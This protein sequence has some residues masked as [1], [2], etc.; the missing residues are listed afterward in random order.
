MVKTTSEAA[1]GTV[2]YMSPEQVL[3]RDL[4]HRSDLFSL[5]VVL[6]EMAT[7]R[8]PFAGANSAETVERI[9]TAQAPDISRFRREVPRVLER[10]VSKCLEKDR[11]RR[12]VSTRELLA[13]LKIARR[14]LDEG[15]RN[16]QSPA[17]YPAIDRSQRARHTPSAVA[18][19]VVFAAASA[20]FVSRFRQLAEPPSREYT[21]LTNFADSARWPTL[22]SDGRMLA[23]IRGEVSRPG[24]VYVKLL[25]DGEPTRLTDDGL[26]KQ[27]PKFSPDGARIAYGALNP[28][29]GWDT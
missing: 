25:P 14:D 19:L 18:A 7:G 22:S 17:V 3:A 20:L 29:T 5:G 23:F 28:T 6:Y 4:D 24:Q 26:Q 1:M 16:A 10:A 15:P 9:L 27:S 8:A 13:D 2:P 12:Y 21:Q 11:D